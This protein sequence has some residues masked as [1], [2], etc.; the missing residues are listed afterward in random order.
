MAANSGSRRGGGSQASS[1]G[2]GRAPNNP[3]TK[4][5]ERIYSAQ[6][7]VAAL[8]SGLAAVKDQL[9]VLTILDGTAA[10]WPGVNQAIDDMEFLIDMSAQTTNRLE[11]DSKNMEAQ[12]KDCTSEV[13]TLKE[14]LALA[15]Q[16]HDELQQD[17]SQLTKDNRQLTQKLDTANKEVQQQRQELW[18]LEKQRADLASEVEKYK[19]DNEFMEG[20]LSTL[21]ATVTEQMQTVTSL[22]EELAARKADTN[23]LQRLTAEQKAQL[24]DLRRQLDAATGNLRTTQNQLDHMRGEK[25]HYEK[26]SERLA[27]ES[28]RLAGELSRASKEIERLKD[29]S[30]VLKKV[31]ADKLREEQQAHVKTKLDS[32]ATR[33]ELEKTVARL[34][35]EVAGWAERLKAKSSEAEGLAKQL[36][37]INIQVKDL[38]KQL[39]ALTA[40][41]A[42]VGRSRDDAKAQAAK[43][44][45]QLQAGV[46]QMA[47]VDKERALTESKAREVAGVEKAKAQAAADEARREAAVQKALAEGW[48]RDLRELQKRLDAEQQRANTLREQLD[49]LL[50]TKDS[51]VNDRYIEMVKSGATMEAIIRE[52]RAQVV[53]KEAEIKR[54]KAESASLQKRLEK[55]IESLQRECNESA[56]EIQRLRQGDGVRLPALAQRPLTFT[57]ELANLKRLVNSMPAGAAPDKASPQPTRLPPAAGAKQVQ[58]SRHPTR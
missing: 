3:M 28:G 10:S 30:E 55:Q 43:L 5:Q 22:K 33:S 50:N 36:G 48:A 32:E 13:A 6:Q 57:D 56:A 38:Q 12:V 23:H 42:A 20:E 11:N 7:L 1:S 44:Q 53:A 51:D 8:R 19:Q 27:D 34:T 37:L 46:L 40:E 21:R 18:T 41:K 29:W 35:A 45:E 2:T 9:Q 49:T 16:K 47:A 39:A 58:I 14:T 52:L 26:E 25:S 24:I 54:V 15:N 31:E 17:V 4:S